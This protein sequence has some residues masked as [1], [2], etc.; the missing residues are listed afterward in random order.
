MSARRT[1]LAAL[2]V[3]ALTACSSPTSGQDGDFEPGEVTMIVP[4][5]A[6]G[7]S[8][9]SGRA[10]AAGIEEVAGANI[11]VENRDGGSGAVGYSYFLGQSGDGNTLLATE[12]A[13]LALPL[14]QDV[15]F[16]YA[17]FTPI[18]KVGDDYTLLVVS[19]DSDFKTCKDVV[20]AAGSERVVAGISGATSLD[21][22]VFTMVEQE[23]DVEFDRVPFESG[24]ELVAALLGSQIEIASLNPSEVI[25]QLESGDLKALC[26]FSEKRYDYDQLAEIPTAKEQGIDV[27][28]AQFRGFL[29]PGGIP[30]SA[31]DYWIDAAK[32]FRATDAYTSYVEDNF[33]QPTPAYGD[34]FTAYL[35]QYNTDLAEAL[36]Q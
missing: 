3:A 22:V 5:G 24:S 20:D 10:I 26:A 17:D 27:A 6:G 21:N 4:F 11:S 29:A 12:T 18:M 16:D 25:G 34:D 14:T 9:A 28:F 31:R 8:D 15:E 23:M 7:G 35:E 36:E 1:A 19:P 32:D 33:M 30:E 13:L 2:S